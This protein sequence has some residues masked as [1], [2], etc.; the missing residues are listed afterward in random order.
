MR[1]K[2]DNSSQ[3]MLNN[4]RKSKRK[5]KLPNRYKDTDCELNKSRNNDNG[6][7]EAK[8]EELLD[9]M[10]LS[11][12]GVG[13]GKMEVN[14]GMVSEVDL[15]GTDFPT[16]DESV[17]K[18]EST[19][20]VVNVSAEAVTAVSQSVCTQTPLNVGSVFLC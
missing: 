10:G 13:K 2:S 6:S 4:G 7:L 17:G 16:L 14:Q 9:N 11:K 12:N 3:N 1:N 15:T 5:I 20:K 18:K 19:G 8:Q